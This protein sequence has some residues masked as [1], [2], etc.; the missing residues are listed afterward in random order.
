MS[1]PECS[2][3]TRTHGCT[4]LLVPFWPC[5]VS[6]HGLALS[7]V[8]VPELPLVSPTPCRKKCPSLVVVPC[9]SA[10]A[11]SQPPACFSSR[12]F[13]QRFPALTSLLLSKVPRS[14][15]SKE[16]P[17]THPQRAPL[18]TLHRRT[19]AAALASLVLALADGSASELEAPLS[20]VL[21]LPPPTSK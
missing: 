12:W 4:W 19:A 17:L 10:P 13:L 18:F 2:L 15:V 14:L 3:H 5:L 11:P 7:L 1:D 20:C 16:L 6:L 21:A 9:R 8:F